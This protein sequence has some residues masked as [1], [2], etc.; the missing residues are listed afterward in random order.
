MGPHE[1]G[2][3]HEIKYGT[4]HFS[5]GTKVYVY[6][7]F[8]G[9]GNENIVVIG[10]PRNKRNFIEVIVRRRSVENFR[11]KKV[12]S[13]AVLKRMENSKYSYWW[14][15]SEED[16]NRIIQCVHYFNEDIRNAD[17]P[18][19]SESS[20]GKSEESKRTAESERTAERKSTV[21]EERES[22]FWNGIKEM[23]G[24]ARKA[25][26]NVFEFFEYI[27]KALTKVPPNS[28]VRSTEDLWRISEESK[29]KLR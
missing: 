23:P 5:A 26:E 15:N 19:S 13:P 8:G 14:G 2:E 24:L 27:L 3:E 18:D 12:F 16:R 17:K 25:F 10:I 11:C 29:E 22:G 1:F 4:K 21:S 7:E 6:P 9:M 28:I 20:G